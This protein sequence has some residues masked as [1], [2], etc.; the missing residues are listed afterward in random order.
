MLTSVL[1]PVRCDGDTAVVNADWIEL[2]FDPGKVGRR[3]AVET[4]VARLQIATLV[5][6]GRQVEPVFSDGLTG[7]VRIPKKHRSLDGS[8]PPYHTVDFIEELGLQTFYLID[9]LAGRGQLRL[10]RVDR[11]DRSHAHV[12]PRRRLQVL[13]LPPLRRAATTRLTG[14][15]G[16]DVRDPS[17]NARPDISVLQ[18]SRR[19]APD[20]PQRLDRTDGH[21][22]V[23]LERQRVGGVPRGDASSRG[24]AR[25]GPM[26]L[27]RKHLRRADERRGDPTRRLPGAGTGDTFL[28]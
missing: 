20:A 27:A 11:G 24:S 28:R 23:H 5:V 4:G 10:R 25:R 21:A 22:G 1:T 15:R 3:A 14:R 17:G 8:S 26:R 2:Y 16:H 6:T 9:E 7:V 12:R 18:R 19:E 13:E